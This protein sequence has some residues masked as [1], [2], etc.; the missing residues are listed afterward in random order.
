MEQLDARLG[1]GNWRPWFAY[2]YG[3][4]EDISDTVR[5][6]LKNVGVSCCLSA[7]GG[8]NPPDFDLYDIK[9]QGVDWKFSALAFRAVI[10]GWKV[11]TRR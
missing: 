2:P 4:R 6:V 1:P 3:K 7:Y 5:F 11:R 8:V 9:R 10:E